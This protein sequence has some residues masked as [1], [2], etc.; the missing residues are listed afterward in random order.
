MRKEEN[1]CY[2]VPDYDVVTSLSLVLLGECKGKLE[3]YASHPANTQ[4]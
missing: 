4:H 1:I 2:V 3:T